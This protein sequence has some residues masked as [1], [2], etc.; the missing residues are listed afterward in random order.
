MANKNLLQCKVF[1]IPTERADLILFTDTK[2]IKYAKGEQRNRY[3]ENSPQFLHI[4]SSREIERGCWYLFLKNNTVCK[5]DYDDENLK[6]VNELREKGHV[7]RIEATT[8]TSIQLGSIPDSFMEAFCKAKGDIKEVNL[9]ITPNSK[10]DIADG[11]KD[12]F[13]KTRPDNSVII[14][15]AK[16]Y[17][18]KE[19]ADLI[20]TAMKS[21]AYT[22]VGDWNKFIEENL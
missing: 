22:S 1:M 6:V 5:A 21:R 20:Y 13:I 3:A 18:R 8:D 4:T 7:R 14:H 12:Y 19:V 9:E 11:G 2:D 16:M 17:S 15:R 10:G